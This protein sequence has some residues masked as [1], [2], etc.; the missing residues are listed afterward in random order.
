MGAYVCGGFVI[1]VDDVG[2]TTL[3]S[4]V[5]LDVSK[6]DLDFSATL[7]SHK[8]RVFPKREFQLTGHVTCEQLGMDGF[9]SISE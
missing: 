3:V 8:P 2:Y 1:Y 4:A 6:I 9:V 5:A 7:T